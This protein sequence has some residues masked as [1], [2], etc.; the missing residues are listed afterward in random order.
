MVQHEPSD[1]SADTGY[2][3]A[4]PTFGAMIAL[5]NNARFK[6]GKPPMGFLNPWLYK[7][8]KAGFTE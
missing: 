1:M 8:G 6:K 3:V 5:I 2:S 4:A 7:T